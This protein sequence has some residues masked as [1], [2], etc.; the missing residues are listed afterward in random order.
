MVAEQTQLST[1]AGKRSKSS[2]IEERHEPSMFVAEDGPLLF[3]VAGDRDGTQEEPG[4]DRDDCD[5]RNPD[6]GGVLQPV[7]NCLAVR[8][9]SDLTVA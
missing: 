5:Q 9:V 1:E 3:D 6:P 4:E 7:C 8:E 2:V